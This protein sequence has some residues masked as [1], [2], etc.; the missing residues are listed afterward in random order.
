MYPCSFL[1]NNVSIKLILCHEHLGLIFSDKMTRSDHI[2][3]ICKR[4]N[5]RLDI[6]SKM[7]YLLPSLCIEKLHKIFVRSLLEYP[8]VIYDNCSNIDSTKIEHIQ[9]RAC[10]I[11]TGV[12]RAT[13]YK[14]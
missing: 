5:K 7:R 13:Q 14:L 9:R 10:I 4:S 3:D 1:L 12:I 8:D 11:L 6:I 2:D